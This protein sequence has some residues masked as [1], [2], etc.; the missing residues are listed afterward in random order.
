MLELEPSCTPQQVTQ[1]PGEGRALSYTLSSSPTAQFREDREEVGAGLQPI[2][3]IALNGKLTGLLQP[4]M[5]V[6]IFP[7][8]T[9]QKKNVR[10]GNCSTLCVQGPF[11]GK[12]SGTTKQLLQARSAPVGS[13]LRPASTHLHLPTT[14]NQQRTW[15]PL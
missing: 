14:R 13:W 4:P 5:S 15:S 3:L 2:K 10:A 6:L 1:E 12:T 7:G 8:P 9:G 11:S